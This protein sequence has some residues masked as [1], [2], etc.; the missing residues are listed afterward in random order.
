MK[1]KLTKLSIRTAY[2]ITL[3]IA[4]AE[5]LSADQAKAIGNTRAGWYASTSE[6]SSSGMLAAGC[7]Y[8]TYFGPTRP[9]PKQFRRMKKYMRNLEY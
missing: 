5:Y 7:E 8:P 4:E 3:H 6:E 2:S 9:T 1:T